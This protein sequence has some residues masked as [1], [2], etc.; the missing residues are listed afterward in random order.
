L[1]SASDA[2]RASFARASAIIAWAANA[3][4]QFARLERRQ[5]ESGLHRLFQDP[6]GRLRGDFFDF[7]AAVGRGHEYI[8]AVRPIEHD[9]QVQLALDRQGFFDQDAM[10]HAAFR[11]GLMGHQRHT[12]NL[13]RD[14]GSFPGIPGDFD[15]SALA[16]S[17]RMNLRLHDHAAADTRRCRRGFFHRMRYLA[18]RHRDTVA[19]QECLGLVFM[20][21]HLRCYSGEFPGEFSL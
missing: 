4:G 2:S 11:T 16:A 14:L 21:F 6:L 18:S 13:L 5:T 12:Q 20:D 19:R 9:A 3:E 10:N 8:L 1:I 7:H 17:A 15:A